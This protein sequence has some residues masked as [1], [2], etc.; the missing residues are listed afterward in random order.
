MLWEGAWKLAEY[1]AYHKNLVFVVSRDLRAL[2]K[3]AHKAHPEIHAYLIDL[4]MYRPMWM[5]DAKS[6]T[7]K[8]LEFTINEEFPTQEEAVLDWT[9]EDM[10]TAKRALRKPLSIPA[11][12]R[13]LPGK[14]VHV[15]FDGGSEDRLGTGGFVIIDGEGKDI[16]RMGT[17]YGA[18]G[19]T[20]RLRCSPLGTAWPS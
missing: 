19:P 15:Q 20:T 16:I 9:L 4:Q 18:G 6:V 3:I 2:L 11:K 14:F 17:Y 12:S 13:F 10:A 8:E 5:V 1:A 7:P